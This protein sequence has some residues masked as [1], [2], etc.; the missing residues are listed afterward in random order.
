MGLVPDKGLRSLFKKGPKYRL[1]SSIDQINAEVLSRKYFRHIA[2]DCVRR[3][4]SECMPLTT[5]KNKFLRILDLRIEN[6]T[7]HP[8]LYKQPPSRSVK[9]EKEDGKITQ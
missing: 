7:I 8:N 6:F 9:A 4:V 3:K 2:N 1:P 5:E